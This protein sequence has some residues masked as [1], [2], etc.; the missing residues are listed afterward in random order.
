MTEKYNGDALLFM[1]DQ[2][3]DPLSKMSN[4]SQKA[5]SDLFNVDEAELTVSEYADAVNNAFSKAFPNDTETQ[6]KW[7]KAFGYSDILKENQEQLDNLKANDTVKDYTDQIDSL[8]NKDLEIALD[9]VVNDG[10][11]GTFEELQQE[12]EKTKKATENEALL[13]SIQKTV[14]DAQTNLSSFQSAIN[15]SASA[16]GLSAESITA[17]GNAFSEFSELNPALLFMNTAN[18]VKVNNKALSSLISLQ[19]KVKSKDFSDAIKNQTQAIA[20]QNEVVKNASADNLA[21]EQG[22]LQKMFGDLSAIQQARS[23]YNALY[24]EQQKLFSDYGEWVTATSTEN[25]GDPFLNMVSGLEQAKA[26]YDKGLVGTDEFKSFAKLISPT[27]ATDA[28]NFMENY[29]KAARYLTEDISG[30]QNFLSDLQTNGFAEY[31]AELD[32]WALNVRNVSDVA[33]KTGY[34]RRFHIWY[35]WKARR[36]RIP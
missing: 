28:A 31:N 18:G 27:G 8:S 13:S 7:K 4:E 19:H 14:T 5:I 10:W 30:V 16:T 21:E 17:V 1:Y 20:E 6:D 15:E 29:G 36:L 11:K 25:A 9:L 35:V 2:F 34:G 3:I 26:A 23:Q 24:Q 32:S 33:K 22:K 12:I